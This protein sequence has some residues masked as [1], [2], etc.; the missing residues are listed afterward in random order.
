[1]NKNKNDRTILFEDLAEEYAREFNEV[2][3]LERTQK[4][5]LSDLKNKIYFFWEEFLRQKE[6]SYIWYSELVE[7]HDFINERIKE[8]VREITRRKKCKIK[9]S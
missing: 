2:E 6:K 7:V 3:E 8:E 4:I 1:M 5:D 9:R